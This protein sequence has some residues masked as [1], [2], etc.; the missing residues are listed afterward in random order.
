MRSAG[1]P[2]IYIVEGNFKDARFSYES[3]AGAVMDAVLHDEIYLFR[4]WD[5]EE[6]KHLLQQL[7]KKMP[8]LLQG[9]AK[10]EA[11]LVS[12]RKKDSAVE[13]IWVKMLA[14]IPTFSESVCRAIMKH[15][16]TL[17]ELQEHLRDVKNFPRIALNP[18]ECLGPAR[19]NKLAES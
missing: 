4:T 17:A 14:C 8:A 2:A 1:V 6:T 19:I 9:K 12:K 5:L 16:G 15:F 11:T 10:N 18:K 3:L 7:V 13:H